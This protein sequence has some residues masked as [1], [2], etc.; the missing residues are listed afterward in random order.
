M[1]K[2]LEAYLV[3]NYV[4]LEGESSSRKNKKKEKIEKTK[5]GRGG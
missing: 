3:Y 5:K 4:C 2:H 1:A